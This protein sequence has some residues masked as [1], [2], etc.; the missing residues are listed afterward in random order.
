MSSLSRSS[1]S[2]YGPAICLHRLP[3][4]PSACRG[5]AYVDGLLRI[6]HRLPDAA[7]FLHETRVHQAQEY[8]QVRPKVILSHNLA[9][10]EHGGCLCTEFFA[11]VW[12]LSPPSRLVT[13]P[14]CPTVIYPG[15]GGEQILGANQLRWTRLYLICGRFRLR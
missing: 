11:I 15:P 3:F 1:K 13:R 12:L 14:S 8:M 10:K 9:R 5:A 2:W 6:A 7:T 4:S